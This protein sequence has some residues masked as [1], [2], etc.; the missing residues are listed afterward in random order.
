MI[1]GTPAVSLA[2]GGFGTPESRR[3]GAIGEQ[4][5]A[6]ILN[7]FA[8]R[9]AIFHD[10]QVPGQQINIDHAV[11]AGRRLLLIDSKLWQAGRYWS[12]GETH[13]RGLHR[14][15][16]PSQAVTMAY[17]A[18]RRVLPHHPMPTPLVVLW[19]G[20][21]TR[22]R[23]IGDQ[24][25]RPLGVAVDQ[26]RTARPTLLYSYPG[27]KAVTGNKLHARI[28]RFVRHAPAPDPIAVT[29]L[30]KHLNR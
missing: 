21:Q 2:T 24:Y 23:M 22:A 12:V 1:Y 11:L 6:A 26:S 18:Y 7:G 20:A 14:R 16:T 5:T 3:A 13:F 15:D 4:M 9:A 30:L 27:A 8:D 28:T 25:G 17:D 19:S 29:T 10:L